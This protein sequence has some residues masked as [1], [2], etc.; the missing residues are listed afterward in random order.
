MMSSQ[1]QQQQPRK[2]TMVGGYSNLGH[3][4]NKKLL[5]SKEVIKVANFALKEYAAKTTTETETATSSSSSEI[6]QHDSLTV[7]P[8]QVESGEV[9][10]VVLEAHRQVSRSLI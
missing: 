9:T 7:S 1:Q 10:A 8:E 4:N 5:Q 3:D 6:Q 2:H